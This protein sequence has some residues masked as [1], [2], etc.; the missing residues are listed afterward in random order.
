MFFYFNMHVFNYNILI[1]VSSNFKKRNYKKE[2]K[3]NFTF[4]NNK[5]KELV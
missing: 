5:L 3:Y 2:N 1:F 4:I